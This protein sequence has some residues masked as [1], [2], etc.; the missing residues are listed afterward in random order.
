M[1]MIYCFE[2]PMIGNVYR[3]YVLPSTEYVLFSVVLGIIPLNS[4]Y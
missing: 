2:L 4:F 3:K 1:E